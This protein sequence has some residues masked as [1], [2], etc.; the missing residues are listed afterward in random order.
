MHLDYVQQGLADAYNTYHSITKNHLSHSFFNVQYIWM[1]CV[2]QF[3]FIIL[4]SSDRAHT[5]TPR[6]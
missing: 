2:L 1:L 5:H 6:C 3:S 4:F